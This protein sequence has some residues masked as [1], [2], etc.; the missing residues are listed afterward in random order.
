MTPVPGLAGKHDD[1][2]CAKLA[3]NPVRDGPT[4]EIHFVHLLVGILDTLLDRRRHL[5]GLA[6]AP[7]HLTATVAD[8][9]QSIES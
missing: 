3:D 5:I 8:H 1:S 9:D 7:G 2:C 4:A 6:V